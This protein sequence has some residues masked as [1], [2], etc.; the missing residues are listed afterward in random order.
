MSDS[1]E[2]FYVGYLKTAPTRL[3]KA[4]RMR[5]LLL[6]VIALGVA[7]F[8]GS[9]QKHFT[10]G[11]FECGTFRTF[12]GILLE[13]P[14]PTLLVE[15]PDNEESTFPYSR[16]L[17]VNPFKFGAEESVAGLNGQRI[18][19]EGQLIYQDDSTMIEVVPESVTPLEGS[20]EVNLPSKEMGMHTLRGEIVDSKC[21]LGVMNPGNLKTH[22]ACAVRCI[23]GGIPPVFLVRK[24]D[25]AAMYFMMVDEQGETVNERVLPLVADPLEITGKVVLEGGMLVLYSDPETFVRIED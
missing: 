3:G 1:N 2:E 23:S 5:I 11:I 14:Y 20:A 8:I 21:Y 9:Q 7:V 18:T 22:K 4:T 24:A 6:V 13:R 17:L 25:G 12:E 10:P 15:R 19:L 16:Y